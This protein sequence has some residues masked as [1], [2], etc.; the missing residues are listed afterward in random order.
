[1]FPDKELQNRLAGIWQRGADGQLSPLSFPLSR[2]LDANL[3][4]Q[5]FNSGG[6]GLYGSLREFSGT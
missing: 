1:M 2:A 6:A 3:V 5:T 4:G